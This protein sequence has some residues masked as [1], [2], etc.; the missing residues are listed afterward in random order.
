MNKLTDTMVMKPRR[1]FKCKDESKFIPRSDVWKD[2]KGDYHCPTCGSKV[3]DVTNTETGRSC[4][5]I[6]AI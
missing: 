2:G 6:I 3:E 4:L 1:I 5:E